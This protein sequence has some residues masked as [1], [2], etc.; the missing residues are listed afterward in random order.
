MKGF[1]EPPPPSSSLMTL[2]WCY[3]LP[4]P[5]GT[6]PLRM[7]QGPRTPSMTPRPCGLS[8]MNRGWSPACGLKGLAFEAWDA[9]VV[10]GENPLAQE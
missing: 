4:I 7:L 9:S 6:P 10:P 3:S 5:H 2:K 1:A 8:H